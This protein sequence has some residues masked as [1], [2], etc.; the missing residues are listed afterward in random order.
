MCL[1]TFAVPGVVERAREEPPSCWPV[2]LFRGD[3]LGGTGGGTLALSVVALVN[4]WEPRCFTG[5]GTACFNSDEEAFAAAAAVAAAA[6]C[7]SALSL[8]FSRC[9]LR[10]TFS[11]CVCS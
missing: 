5:G 9:L 11:L 6:A 3:P 4:A 10:P 2:S 7:C 8:S 1:L